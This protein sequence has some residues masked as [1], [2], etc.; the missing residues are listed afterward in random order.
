MARNRCYREG[1]REPPEVIFKK[2]LHSVSS[3]APKLCVDPPLLVPCISPPVDLGSGNRVNVFVDA[4][5][6]VSFNYYVVLVLDCR[7]RLSRPTQVFNFLSCNSSCSICWVSRV[8]IE[9]AHKLAAWAASQ[10][11]SGFFNLEFVYS[12]L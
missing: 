9:A 12:V 5:V 2:I 10:R 6:R 11:F 1:V 8:N 3:H 7:E 4:A